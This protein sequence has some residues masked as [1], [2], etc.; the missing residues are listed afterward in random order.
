MPLTYRVQNLI[1]S[2]LLVLGAS[3]GVNLLLDVIV[4]PSLFGRVFFV[5]SGV[6]PPLAAFVDRVLVISAS[7]MQFFIGFDMLRQRRRARVL[8]LRFI[9]LFIAIDAFEAVRAISSYDESTPGHAGIV[10]QSVIITLTTAGFYVWL[11]LFCRSRQAEEL[12]TN[13]A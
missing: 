5:Q 13:V 11:Y 8:V 3:F 4:H 10:I 7:W 12:M 1:L 9:P 2:C 6:F